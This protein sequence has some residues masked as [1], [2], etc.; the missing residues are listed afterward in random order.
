MFDVMTT[1]LMGLRAHTPTI[2]VALLFVLAL[3]CA[4]LAGF[5]MASAPARAWIHEVCFAA[6]VTLTVY[7]ILDIEYPRIGL[8]NLH[9]VDEVLAEVRAG[10]K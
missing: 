8:I 5:D 7:I 4:M 10:M 3:G 2:I 1:R 6:V 9:A